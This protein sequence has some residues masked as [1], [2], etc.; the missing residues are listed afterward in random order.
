M[1]NTENGE[2]YHDKLIGMLERLWGDGWLSP[3]G[4]EEV[5]RLLAGMELRGKT[6]LDIGCGAGGIVGTNPSAGGVPAG[7]A[8][9]AAAGEC[10][11]S[12]SRD[13]SRS[14]PRLPGGPLRS[15]R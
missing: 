10:G 8:G 1:G 6:I 4:P 9:S 11:R 3:G 2:L 5:R 12:G 13:V 7:V 14:A 15:R